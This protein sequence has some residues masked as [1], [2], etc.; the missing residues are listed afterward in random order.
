MDFFSNNRVSNLNFKHGEQTFIGIEDNK[1]N[2]SYS[3][4]PEEVVS[5]PIKIRTSDNLNVVDES[6][7]K[8]FWSLNKK[9]EGLPERVESKVINFN[10][11]YFCVVNRSRN[12]F[13]ST[14]L[15]SWEK[16]FTPKDSFSIA[17]L[18]EFNGSLWTATRKR[19]KSETEE[20]YSYEFCVYNSKHG[21]VWNEVASFTSEKAIEANEGNQEIRGFCIDE[22]N[23]RLVLS[24]GSFV[25]TVTPSESDYNFEL[26]ETGL[27]ATCWTLSYFDGV[28]VAGTNLGFYK[29]TDLSN[30]SWTKFLE[31]ETGN[32]YLSCKI[33]GFYFLGGVN[34]YRSDSPDG[35]FEE[36]L[37]CPAYCP[38]VD[39]VYVN[40]K[41][42]VSLNGEAIKYQGDKVL[43]YSTT[44]DRDSWEDGL[45]GFTNALDSAWTLSVVDYGKTLLI[46]SSTSGLSG[47]NVYGTGSSKELATREYVDEIYVAGGNVTWDKVLE[48]SLNIESNNYNLNIPSGHWTKFLLEGN[49]DS[50]INI[51]NTPGTADPYGVRIN[52]KHPDGGSTATLVV[53]GKNADGTNPYISLYTSSED[54]SIIYTYLDVHKDG[55]EFSRLPS[56]S[57]YSSSPEIDRGELATKKYVDE[58]IASTDVEIDTSNLVTLDGSQ[59]ISGVKNFT[60]N[61][62]INGDAVVSTSTIATGSSVGVVRG[63]GNGIGLG[64][65]GKLNIKTT[66]SHSGLAF[67]VDGDDTVADFVYVNTR[68]G[69]DGEH[70][71]AGTS[72]PVATDSEGKLV[73]LNATTSLPGGV[74][75][76]TGIDDTGDISVLTA[77]QVK[78]AINGVDVEIPEATTET[79]GTVLLSEGFDAQEL[80]TRV[81]TKSQVVNKF[82]ALDRPLILNISNTTEISAGVD[83]T[84]DL[85]SDFVYFDMIPM[86]QFFDSE[87]NNVLISYKYDKANKQI[88][89]KSNIDVAIGGLTAVVYATTRPVPLSY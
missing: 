11:G 68:A 61:P 81:L 35:T 5:T 10:N 69:L 48:N 86:I 32:C 70:P 83:Y 47:V 23:N 25:I 40:N 56:V 31:Q 1:K 39:I 26:I 24:S 43:Y 36:I 33:N 49:L 4:S 30:G 65:D 53:N 9:T 74:K 72:A 84:I 3:I 66:T 55:I 18:I 41:Y 16:V 88:I 58:A 44:S 8:L 52:Y 7:G 19:V 50:G 60:A 76:A 75:L 62:T 13:Y 22:G 29:S 54:K 14:N 51:Y 45:N 85:S 64:S 12:I 80:D 57:Q 89:V 78:E 15:K 2:I 46:S 6:A 73:T 59:T 87:G 67:K 79:S 42:F 27:P 82:Y 17:N 37:Q 34:L 63:G 38:P 28:F 71:T 21:F 20:S 77:S